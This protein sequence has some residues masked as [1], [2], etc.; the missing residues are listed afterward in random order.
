LH[1]AEQPIPQAVRTR[2]RF[3]S[4]ATGEFSCGKPVIGRNAR[5]AFR[6]TK[7]DAPGGRTGGYTLCTLY[8]IN[9]RKNLADREF[10]HLLTPESLTGFP[11]QADNTNFLELTIPKSGQ[12]AL[13]FR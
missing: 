7:H 13:N 10:G 4:L 8:L 5:P 3:T 6:F 9:L 1:A 2:F 11:N 12:A